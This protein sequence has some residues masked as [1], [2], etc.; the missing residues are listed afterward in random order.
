M[1]YDFNSHEKHISRVDEKIFFDT[2]EEAQKYVFD[3]N[4]KNVDTKVPD[5]YMVAEYMGSIIVD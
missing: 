3:F 5:W 2:K 4:A 1:A